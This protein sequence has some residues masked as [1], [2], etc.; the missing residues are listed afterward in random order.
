VSV[1]WREF[2]ADYEPR[3]ADEEEVEERV[4]AVAGTTAP[5][6]KPAPAVAPPPPRPTPVPTPPPPAAGKPVALRG[7][8]SK[9]V[10][11]MEMSLTVPTATSV[12][13]IPVKVLEE[14]R[15]VINNHLALTGQSKAS[16][17]HIIAWAIVRAVKDQPR[18]N[19]A[20]AVQDGTP[21][22]IDREDVNLGLAIDIE[23][24]DGTRSLLVRT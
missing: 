16:F 18:M 17:T 3:L 2:F 7:A 13:N 19:S 23:K 4:A 6:I 20:F 11:N 10:A 24:K 12:R 22:R 15:R 5:A 8:A 14:N 21:T 9:I 1:S